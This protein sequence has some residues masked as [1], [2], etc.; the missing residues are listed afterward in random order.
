MLRK[1]KLD[2]KYV[3]L[4]SVLLMPLSSPIFTDIYSQN[5]FDSFV[6]SRYIQVYYI[7]S[8]VLSILG[9]FY[10]YGFIKI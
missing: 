2:K 9:N 5:P 6:Y 7:I 1:S 3:L 8:G 10:I 4:V